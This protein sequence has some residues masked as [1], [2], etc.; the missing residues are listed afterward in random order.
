MRLM[1]SLLTAGLLVACGD[2]DAEDSAV[3]EATEEAE[4]EDSAAEVEE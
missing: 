3:E 4:V 1:I 2:K